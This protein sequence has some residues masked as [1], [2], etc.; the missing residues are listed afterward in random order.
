MLLWS[1]LNIITILLSLISCCGSDNDVRR[2][3]II[4]MMADQQRQDSI[5]SYP[6]SVAITPNIDSIASDGI[7]FT[8]SWTSTPSCTPARAAILTGRSPWGHGMLGYGAIGQK[9]PYELIEPL[10]NIG[11]KTVSFGKNHFG[12]LNGSQWSPVTHKYQYMSLYDGL[13]NGMPKYFNIENHDYGIEYEEYWNS[14]NNNV[15]CTNDAYDNYDQWFQEEF[16]GQDPQATGKPLMDWNS[17]RGAPFIYNES[18]HPTSWVAKQVINYLE[19]IYDKQQPLFLK[20]SFHR[21]HSP[22]DPPLKYINFVKN[23]YNL[24]KITSILHGNIWDT[25]FYNNSWCG[26]NNKDAWC[27]WMKQNDTNNSRITY[28][29]NV[30]FIDDMVGNILLKLKELNLYNSS[31]ILWTADH[32]DQLGD[33][34]LWRKT[35]PYNSNAKIP[36][37]IKWPTINSNTTFNV[38]DIKIKRGTINNKQIIELR[39]LLPTF[40]NVSG[41][42]LPYNWSTEWSGLNINDILY[43]NN[44]KWRNILDLEHSTCYNKTNHWNAL[45][46]GITYKYIYNAYFGNESLFDIINDPNEMNDLSKNIQYNQT[47]IKWRN[48]LI[49]MFQKQQ[50][51]PQW[52]QNGTLQIRLEGQTYG[53]N[54]PDN[55]APCQ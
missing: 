22:Y 47:L 49:T 24:N 15:N 40:H 38:K 5:G 50:R 44:V 51:G 52:V 30:K 4:F 13:G 19:N 37:I 18:N 39:D 48:K 55:A 41:I 7:L 42:K 12:F 34:N 28:Y 10:N 17:W 25:R 8:N 35:Y 9:Y 2:P 14:D 33:H 31:Y 54:F 3:N 27:G 43:N 46:D 36:M 6:G 26:E 45:T 21:P 16:P 29:A 20:I 1:P 11:Y 32:G 23:N 53:P